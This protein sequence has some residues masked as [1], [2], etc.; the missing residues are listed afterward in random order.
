LDEHLQKL[1]LCDWAGLISDG[2]AWAKYR[3]SGNDSHYE[4]TK[5][6]R[7]SLRYISCVPL[8]QTYSDFFHDS[9]PGLTVVFCGTAPL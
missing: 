7:A 9:T 4:K 5:P 6:F 1:Q 2:S 8:R 3:Q